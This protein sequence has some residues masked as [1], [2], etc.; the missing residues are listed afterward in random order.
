MGRSYE[1]IRAAWETWIYLHR[2]DEIEPTAYQ[3]QCGSDTLGRIPKDLGDVVCP[4]C[5][6]EITRP[7][8]ECKPLYERPAVID[9]RRGRA[10]GG[11]GE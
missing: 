4:G 9:V 10:P 1:A 8:S 7:E 2:W 11:P 6:F 5:R 3:H